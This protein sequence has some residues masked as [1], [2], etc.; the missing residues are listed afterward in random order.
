MRG[1]RSTIALLVVLVGLTAYIY[2]VV[3]KKP[4][5]GTESTKE[6]AFVSLDAEKIDE[7]KVKSESGDTTSLKKSAGVWQV[8]APL[9]VK[10]DEMQAG[11]IATNLSTLEIT[12]VVDEN[13]TDLKEYGLDAPRVEIEFKAS[14]DK[15]YGDIHRLVLGGKSATG[16]DLFARRDADKRVILV[17]GYTD[18]IFNRSTFDLRDKTLL[19]FDRQKVDRMTASS[20]G[21]SIELVKEGNDWKVTKPIAAPADYSAADALLS[22]LQTAAMKSVVTEQATP[23]DLKKYGFD[24]PQGTFVLSAGGAMPSLVVGGMAPG[25]DVYVRDASK[26]TVATADAGLVKDVQKSVDD[27]RRKEIFTSR[28]FSTDHLEFTHDGQT[29]V[30]DK[31][32]AQGQTPEKWHRVSPSPGD[33]DPM[34]ME[35]LLV[36]LETF[37][38]ASFVDSLAK[39]G[40]DKPSLTVY[41]KF[42]DGKKEERV[43]FSKVGNDAYASP[44]GQPGAVK[45]TTADYDEL[46]KYLDAVSK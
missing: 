34:K 46:M 39:T 3:S 42:D 10:A 6:R 26:A 25:G 14:G 28:S 13:P 22:R 35:T 32:K 43:S 2:F 30:F 9:M 7:I 33:P 11:S 15:T 8:T 38:G 17:A 4:A 18:P 23:A 37:R 16:G 29:I 41:A 19:A 45:L 5:G 40:L 24:K 36:K 44:P 27:Y 21:K 1:L 12:R 31:V 20:D